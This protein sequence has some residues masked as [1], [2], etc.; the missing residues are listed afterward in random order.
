MK[1]QA[2]RGM[3][4]VLPGEVETWQ[5]IERVARGVFETYGFR[6]IRIP[7]LEST[8]LFARSIGQITDIVEKE[9]YTFT[10]RS[11]AS[12]SLRPEA[13]AGILRACI[14]H[15]LFMSES[16]HKLYCIGPMF[17]R[18]RPQKGRH[19]QFHQI[20]AELLG[21]TDPRADA[22]ILAMLRTFFSELGLGALDFQI[23][24]LGCPTCRPSFR[25][26]VLEFLRGREGD[27]CPDCQRRLELNPLRV[28][29]CKV[30]RCRDLLLGAPRL[31]D[32]L[33]PNC[34]WHFEALR[35]YLDLLGVPHS[36]NPHIVRG[37]DYYTRTAFE[38]MSEELGAQNAVCG[39]GRYD[40]L[41]Q[42]LG[43]PEL[44]GIG[45]AIGEERLVSILMG[46]RPHP[47]RPL[48]LF[49]VALGPEATREALVWT[50][51]ARMI[52]LRTEVDLRGGSLKAQLRRANKLGARRAL[53]L[54]PE[55]LASR[56][57]ALREMDGGI[58][59]E[60]PMEGL[61]DLLTEWATEAKASESGWKRS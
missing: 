58:Q 11:G 10:D 50:D 22:E 18:E 13:T 23:N 4:D 44:P 40:R 21:V 3:R 33:C 17:R 31:L 8:E 9:M 15:S 28:Y 30:D 56:R 41:I 26:S 52:G 27:L 12:L 5:S 55:E 2:V 39:G 57:A 24:S 19:R 59:V 43:G 14:E 1:I 48:E 36:I 51:R 35:G 25:Q 53:I 42:E 47:P 49:V 6:E 61:G 45:F 16:V 32:H 54:G 7:V 38:V 60:V 46:Q 20:D 37:L 34:L 29:D